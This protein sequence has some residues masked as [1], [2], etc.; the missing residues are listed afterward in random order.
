MKRLIIFFVFLTIIGCVENSSKLNAS[1]SEKIIGDWSSEY[2][3]SDLR[4]TPIVFIFNDSNC[5]YIYP[6]GTATKYQIDGDTLTIQE[7]SVKRENHVQEGKKA[8]KFIITTLTESKLHLKPITSETK[9]LFEYYRED[10][11]EIVELSRIEKKNSYQIKRIAFS[12][13]MCM[14][15]CPSMHLEIDSLGH[16]MFNGQNYTEVEGLYSGELSVDDFKMIKSKVQNVELDNLKEFYY[17]D[18]TDDQTCFIYI[19]TEKDTFQCGAY[20]FHGEPVALRILFYELME[21]HKKV[22]LKE[23]STIMNKFQYKGFY[24]D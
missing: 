16:F 1:N 24:Y 22:D 11:L 19:Q 20:G 17:A 18:W 10:P 23:D 3:D 13:S 12:S 2:F 8:Y 15:T 6:A 21:L 4:R 9:K 14:G 7:R 5:N